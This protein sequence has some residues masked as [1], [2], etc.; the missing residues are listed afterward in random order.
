MAMGSQIFYATECF[1]K[2][3]PVRTK[4]WFCFQLLVGEGTSCTW[5]RTFLQREC[6][7]CLLLLS[8]ALPCPQHS[9]GVG[10]KTH[11]RLPVCVFLNNI[12]IL[13]ALRIKWAHRHIYIWWEIGWFVLSVLHLLVFYR[14]YEVI[15]SWFGRENTNH[16][17]FNSWALRN[18]DGSSYFLLYQTNVASKP[19]LKD[20]Q[21]SLHPHSTGQGDIIEI[22]AWLR[23]PRG[24]AKL[25][26]WNG[27]FRELVI[28]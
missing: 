24:K 11:A 13:Q 12:I 14:P 23:A 19:I 7:H 2:K 17:Q 8:P 6:P 28:F 27:L 4:L 10:E 16:Q 15:E 25:Q 1:S 26:I 22:W 18:E 5:T 3:F 20:L 9:E 21:Y